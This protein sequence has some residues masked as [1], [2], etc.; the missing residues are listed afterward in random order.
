MYTA[1]FVVKEHPLVIGKYITVIK[2]SN[3]DHKSENS[4]T[5]AVTN[6]IYHHVRRN[7]TKLSGGQNCGVSLT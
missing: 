6:I 4:L 2:P 7:D 3:S 1:Q 5:M